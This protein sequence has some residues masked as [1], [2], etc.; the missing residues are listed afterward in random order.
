MN[1]NNLN[2]FNEDLKRYSRLLHAGLSLIGE[3]LVNECQTNEVDIK[4]FEK[5]RIKYDSSII[6]RNN[7]NNNSKEDNDTASTSIQ[8]A[9]NRTPSTS[10]NQF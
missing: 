6:I 7:K 8:Y 9:G 4:R 2:V 3:Y 10:S 1:I 5:F